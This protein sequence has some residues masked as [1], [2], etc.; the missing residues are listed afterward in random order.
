M[1]EQLP[2][3]PWRIDVADGSANA[4]HFTSESA[5][6]PVAFVYVPV[7]PEQSST[8]MYSGGPPRKEQLDPADPRLSELWSQLHALE[9]KPAIH[10]PD[11]AKGT[12]AIGWKT[13][14][15][16][17]SFIIEMGADLNALLALLARFGTPD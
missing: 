17:R 16:E 15:G 8:G 12:G 5:S 13:P 1:N 9:A 3:A 7:T 10:T 4:F 11:R 14:A 2:T 6:G